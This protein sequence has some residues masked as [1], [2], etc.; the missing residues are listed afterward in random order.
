MVADPS[1]FRTA[2]AKCPSGHVLVAV[3]RADGGTR[4][5]CPACLGAALDT[6]RTRRLTVNDFLARYDGGELPQV[7]RSDAAGS[8]GL[9]QAAKEMYGDA[10]ATACRRVVADVAKA[11]GAR[12]KD[13]MGWTLDR[14]AVGLQ[15][16]A[17]HECAI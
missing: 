5:V 4:R 16:V 11:N 13:V 12:V 15:A 6:V 17:G 8:V 14:L 7:T 10:D 3:A 2:P 9:L 1:R